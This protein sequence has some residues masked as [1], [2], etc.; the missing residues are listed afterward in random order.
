MWQSKAR[1]IADG[2]VAG[3]IGGA[4]IALWFLVFDAARG[5]P[6]ETPALLVAALQHGTRQPIALT[7]TARRS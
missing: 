6:L 3:L 2:I 1:I 4:V 5:H 7:G